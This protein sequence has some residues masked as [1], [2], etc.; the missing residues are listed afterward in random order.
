MILQVCNLSTIA[1]E[2]VAIQ[3][4]SILPFKDLILNAAG[5][6][7]G[8]ETDGWKI[9]SALKE[10]VE[11]SFNQYQRQAITVSFYSRS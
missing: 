9:P 2:Y 8:T 4:I 10:Y 7:F 1:R 6:D 5:E 11:G 3:T